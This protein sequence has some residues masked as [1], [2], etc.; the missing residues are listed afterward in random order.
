M[1]LVWGWPHLELAVG[2]VPA[3]RPVQVVGCDCFIGIDGDAVDDRHEGEVCVQPSV[4]CVARVC[5]GLWCPVADQL[6]VS[7]SLW[8]AVIPAPVAIAMPAGAYVLAQ[9]GSASWHSMARPHR[10]PTR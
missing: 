6:L 4:A 7:P 8:A 9:K 2:R 1:A 3:R 5:S 10:E